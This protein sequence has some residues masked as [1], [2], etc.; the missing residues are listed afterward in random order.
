V[1]NKSVYIIAGE[2][3][4]D[5][6]GGR[7]LEALKTI[8]PDIHIHG[9]GG[10]MMQEQGVNS[11]FPMAEL[12]VMGVAEILPKLLHFLRRIRQTADDIIAKQP[13]IVVTI[14]SPDFTKHVV[15]RARPHCSNTN[16]VHYVAPSVWAWRAGRA[17][18]MAKLYDGLICLLPFEPPY[19]EQQNLRT[20][21]CGH[22][23]VEIVQFGKQENR[24]NNHL[25]ILPGSRRGEVSR[26]API[27][28]QTLGLLRH[29]Q[30]DLR[31]SIVALPHVQDIIT[32]AFLG[33][34]VNYITPDERFY[35]FQTTG[36]ALATS[37]TV[38]LELAVAGCAHVIAYKMNLVTF[39]LARRLVKTKY[40]HLV[41]IMENKAVVPE[42]L[43][44]NAMAKNLC[45]GLQN[46]NS[47]DLY[48]IRSKLAGKSP[49]L[50]PSMQAALFVN[51]FL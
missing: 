29:N 21:F 6:L 19:F 8:H 49:E 25:L 18:T 51:S 1:S 23:A 32:N 43:Q 46:L 10:S 28:A 12:S 41:N 4:G 9:I 17:K 35:T 45:H 5:I 47:G 37:G 2:V 42:Y 44:K 22:P 48:G 26:M 30:P 34:D 50:P 27:F 15:K 36:K 14:D 40:V 38:G 24:D 7:L 31:A 33:Q 16:F 13:D 3:S 11:L 39:W 20:E